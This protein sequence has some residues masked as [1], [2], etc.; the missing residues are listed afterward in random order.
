M[1]YNANFKGP[2]PAA[3][4]HLQLT[5]EVIVSNG[6]IERLRKLHADILSSVHPLYKAPDEAIRAARDESRRAA[7]ADREASA[8][9][10]QGD[11]APPVGNSARSAKRKKKLAKAAVESARPISTT[12]SDMRKSTSRGSNAVTNGISP[13]PVLTAS[14]AADTDNDP[15][16]GEASPTET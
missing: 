1:A 6:D 2:V 13:S 15:I 10:V 16:D 5:P 8:A 7:K 11:S 4:G 12:S 3:V 14:L 9:A